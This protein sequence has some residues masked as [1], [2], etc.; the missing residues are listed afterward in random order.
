MQEPLAK[1]VEL[2]WDENFKIP[3]YTG[4]HWVWTGEPPVS[5]SPLKS[6]K[7]P[8]RPHPTAVSNLTQGH[9]WGMCGP[10]WGLPTGREEGRGSVGV[11][12]VGCR[13]RR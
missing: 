8:H 2:G 10:H 9:Q 3:P 6:P 1:T 12:T 11:T 13:V 4:G 5:K 7:S